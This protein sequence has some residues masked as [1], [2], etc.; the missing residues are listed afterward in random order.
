[1]YI[2][3]FCRSFIK[4]FLTGLQSFLL[5]QRYNILLLILYILFNNILTILFIFQEEIMLSPLPLPRLHPIS[6]RKVSTNHS[7]FISPHKQHPTSTVPHG[8]DLRCNTP[9]KTGNNN[10]MMYCIDRSPAKVRVRGVCY[11]GSKGVFKHVTT[12]YICCVLPFRNSKRSTVW[13]AA[14]LCPPDGSVNV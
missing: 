5:G 7:V 8:A 2:Y 11:R 6:P 9:L 1:M 3:I 13:Y 4:R 10:S 14:V 12:N